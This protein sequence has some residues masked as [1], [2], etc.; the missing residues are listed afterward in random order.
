MCLQPYAETQ[1]GVRWSN[2][3]RL[4]IPNKRGSS[5]ENH[6][7][8]L[9]RPWHKQFKWV[10]AR[11]KIVSRLIRLHKLHDVGRRIAILTTKRQRRNFEF[12]VDTYWQLVTRFHH[13]RNVIKFLSTTYHA[14]CPDVCCIDCSYFF[15]FSRAFGQSKKDRVPIIKQ[16][17]KKMQKSGVL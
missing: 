13:I 7:I 2:G 5:W 15:F 16:W 6:H 4:L 11:T 10:V 14:C 9:T 1:Q 17:E 12:N 3:K 8:F